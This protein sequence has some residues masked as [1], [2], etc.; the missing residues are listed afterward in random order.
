M[1]LTGR[2]AAQIANERTNECTL[3]AIHLTDGR[4]YGW[5]MNESEHSAS[6]R[7]P[8]NPSEPSIPS[9]ARPCVPYCTPFLGYTSPISHKCNGGE[10]TVSARDAKHAI[11]IFI[12]DGR[13]IRR[14]A[15]V[16]RMSALCTCKLSPGAVQRVCCH[17]IVKRRD[18]QQKSYEAIHAKR[19][20]LREI[21]YFGIHNA[22]GSRKTFYV[23]ADESGRVGVPPSYQKS[24]SELI[25]LYALIA[26]PAPAHVFASSLRL[27]RGI[28]NGLVMGAE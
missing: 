22:D 2:R 5:R 17:V 20:S 4:A 12:M 25:F 21:D 28:V 14:A 10:T 11:I 24:V 13:T 16:L 9:L 27:A 19:R 18:R 7:Q 3:S 23:R 8:I 15:Y 1:L 6:Q 26:L